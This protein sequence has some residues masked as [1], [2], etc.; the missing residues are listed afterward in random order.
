MAGTLGTLG[1]WPDTAGQAVIFPSSARRT[2]SQAVASLSAVD[3][4]TLGH[5]VILAGFSLVPN[6]LSYGSPL[7][8]AGLA[9]SLQ[10][11]RAPGF[12]GCFLGHVLVF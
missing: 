10:P 5:C 3:E 9:P 4:M 1:T 7:A 11:L 8:R 12:L 2:C 6:T